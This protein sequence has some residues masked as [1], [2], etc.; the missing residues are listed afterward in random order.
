VPG[1]GWGLLDHRGEPKAALGHLTRVLSPVAVWTTDEGLGGIAVHVANDR[2]QPLSAR[3]RLALYRDG[4]VRIEEA[5]TEIRLDGH[6]VRRLD[7]EEVL[8]HFVDVSWAYRFGPAVADVVAVTLEDEDGGLLSQAFRFPAGRP[9]DPRPAAELGLS[10]ELHADGSDRAR[11]VIAV[12]R[13]LYGVRIEAPGWRADD[14]A[15][16]VEPGRPREVTLHRTGEGEG[17]RCALRA[18]NLIGIRQL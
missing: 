12:D 10:T 7:A 3:L 16:C 1:A 15:F 4:A 6:Q 9:L 18:L 2:P 5:T 8:G 11:L 14:D 17:P 13:L